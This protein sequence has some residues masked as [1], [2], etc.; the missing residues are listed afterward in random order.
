MLPS[1]PMWLLYPWRLFA[2]MVCSPVLHPSLQN[3]V[4]FGMPVSTP[5]PPR[6]PKQ[7]LVGMG[8]AGKLDVGEPH[9]RGVYGQRT[10]AVKGQSSEQG[11]QAK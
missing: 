6:G 9:Q 5:H 11:A 7:V 2:L 1:A 4:A 8:R 3:A 10:A